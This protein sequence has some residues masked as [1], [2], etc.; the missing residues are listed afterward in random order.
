MSH[1]VLQF[2]CNGAFH[3]AVDYHEQRSRQRA[4]QQTAQALHVPHLLTTPQQTEDAD[5]QQQGWHVRRRSEAAAFEYSAAAQICDYTFTD[6]WDSSEITSLLVGKTAQQHLQ[7]SLQ[8]S[9]F[10]QQ[11]AGPTTADTAAIMR[12][13]VGDSLAAQPQRTSCLEPVV[14]P[15]RQYKVSRCMH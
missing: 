4:A 3:A 15:P 12:L 11:P 5:E 2:P 8:P 14:F 7:A 1:L 9:K 6:R 13:L 10:R